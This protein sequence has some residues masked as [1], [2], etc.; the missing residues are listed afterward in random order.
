[1]SGGIIKVFHNSTL[2][3]HAQ[4]RLSRCLTIPTRDLTARIIGLMGYS[5]CAGLIQRAL[6]WRSGQSLDALDEAPEFIRFTVEQ[7]NGDGI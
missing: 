3:I 4:L 7:V 1:L 6:A 5:L 2:D